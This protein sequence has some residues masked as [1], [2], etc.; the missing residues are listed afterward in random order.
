MLMVDVRCVPAL[1]SGRAQFVSVP[2]VPMV[3]WGPLSVLTRPV[4]CPVTLGGSDGGA[5]L[6]LTDPI[7]S[8]GESIPFDSVL[9]FGAGAARLTMG[10]PCLPSSAFN[11]VFAIVYFAPTPLPLGFGVVVEVLG[12][13]PVGTDTPPPTY[14]VPLPLVGG[15]V[16]DVVGGFAGAG[17]GAG[18]ELVVLVA[19]TLAP[20]GARM[21][22]EQEMVH[23]MP[24]VL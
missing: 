1:V 21:G 12:F 14:I 10:F 2:L 18:Q 3:P 4:Y 17:A 16:V 6:L 7:M 13:E 24:Q 8:I 22:Q 11:A 5:Q 9:T 19:N 15:L 23:L 20:V